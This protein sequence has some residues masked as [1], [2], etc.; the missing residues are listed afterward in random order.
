[1]PRLTRNSR[2]CSLSAPV[3]DV[4][5]VSSVAELN[6]ETSTATSM[7]MASM[8]LVSTSASAS[9]SDGQSTMNIVDDVVQALEGRIGGLIEH[10]ID[11]RLSMLS[12]NVNSTQ[13]QTSTTSCVSSPSFVDDLTQRAGDLASMGSSSS[14]A[15]FDSAAARTSTGMPRMV[16][17]LTNSRGRIA[18]NFINTLCTPSTNVVWSCQNSSFAPEF[19]VTS[20]PSVLDA[21]SSAND[22]SLSSLPGQALSPFI[23]GPGYAP[24]PAKT[25]HAIVT[26]KYINLGDLL[27]DNSRATD[28]FNEPQLLLDGRLVLT[29]AAR[30]PRKE[31]HDIL[32][33]VEAFTVY[34]VILASHFPHRWRDL[35]SYKLLIL[36]TYRQFSGSAWCEYDKAF[37]QHAAASKLSDWS[38]IN[39][40]LFNFHTAGAGLR[41]YVASNVS[42]TA[43]GSSFEPLGNNNRDCSVVCLSWNK[44]HCVAR[45]AVC[46]FKHV[47][48]KCFAPHREIECLAFSTPESQISNAGTKKRRFWLTL[49]I[50]LALGLVFL[51][52]I[53]YCTY[54]FTYIVICYLACLR[55]LSGIA[56]M[57]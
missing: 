53:I 5:S 20:P 2:D 46:R 10:A 12:A 24:I 25:V 15:T 17:C 37:R 9:V 31:I 14:M 49:F 8:S 36:R 13:P 40:Q 23:V 52:L 27:P 57:S 32:S 19:A 16:N 54:T 56:F 3:I 26:G 45:A 21:V 51:G 29:G 35:A 1:M 4:P 41:S 42:R 30:K 55:L 6:P 34:S 47:C 33:W 48:S 50:Q 44:G 43:T 39:V 38:G 22:Y 28:D 18:P 11:A 7:P